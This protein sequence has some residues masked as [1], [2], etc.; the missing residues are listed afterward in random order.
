MGRSSGDQHAGGS[1]LCP[2]RRAADIRSLKLLFITLLIVKREC[3]LVKKLLQFREDFPHF[4]KKRRQKPILMRQTDVC[5]GL[6]QCARHG[7]KHGE[8]L[9]R[10]RQPE[11]YAECKGIYRAARF[12]ESRA[13]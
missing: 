7:H 6:L 3:K 2:K 13:S 11:V 9:Q 1:S 4:I 8:S 10:A 12:E 5:G